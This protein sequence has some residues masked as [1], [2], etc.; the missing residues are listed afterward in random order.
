MLYKILYAYVKL[1]AILPMRVLY[2][3]SDVFYFLAYYLVRYRVKVV[4]TNLRNAFPDKTDKERLLIERQ[5]YHNFA[6]YIVETFKLAHISKEEVQRRAFLRNPEMVA[7]LHEKGHTCVILLMGHLFNWEWF[8]GSADR[9][10][11]SN[12]YQIYRPL[13][14]KAFDDLFIT[15]RTR[16]GSFGLRKD[17]TMRKIISLKRSGECSAVIFIADQTPSID[18]IHH[19]SIFMNQESGFFS[20]PERLAK[21]LDLPLVFLHTK[22]LAR[23]QYEIELELL[24]T[25]PKETPDLWIT[26]QYVQMMNKVVNEDPSNWL[27][28]HRRWK[29]SKESVAAWRQSQ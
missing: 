14:A 17:D 16:F 12:V 10:E 19:W 27:W 11:K 28:S 15:L 1:H 6:D 23:G 29:H 5:F 22:R 2:V 13:E 24:T 20:G 4:R 3:L 21:K 25:T 9:F 18:S 7:Q 26:E 8:S